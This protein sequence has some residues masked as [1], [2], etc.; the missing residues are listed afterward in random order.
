MLPRGGIINRNDKKGQVTIFVI[1]ALVIVVIAGIYIATKYGTTKQEVSPQ[2]SQIEEYYTSC[3]G[4]LTSQGISIIKNR[5]G[6]IQE[7]LFVRGTPIEPLSSQMNYLGETVPYWLYIKDKKVVNQAPTK[8]IMEEQLSNYIQSRINDCDFSQYS[9]RGFIIERKNSPVVEVAINNKEVITKVVDGITYSDSQTTQLVNTHQVMLESNLGLLYSKAIELY[10]KELQNSYIENYTIDI[11]RLYAPVD[12]VELSCA[13]IVWKEREIFNDLLRAIEVNMQ[14]IRLDDGKT[15]KDKE[16]KYFTLPIKSDGIRAYLKYSSNWFT[17]MSIEQSDGGI[18]IANPVGNQ[19]GLG[20]L[21]FC[22]VPYHLVYDLDYPL[23][24]QLMDEDGE[25][26]QY[27]IQIIIRKNHAREAISTTYDGIENNLCEDKTKQIEVRTYDE[28]TLTPIEAQ[29]SFK[30]LSEGC[31]LGETRIDSSNSAS[32]ILRT[33]QCVNGFLTAVAEGYEREDY[34]ISTNTQTSANILLKK[35]Y[36]IKFEVEYEDGEEVKNN[37]F[38]YFLPMEEGR[39]IKTLVWPEQKSIKITEG[40]YNITAY[41][42]EESNITLPATSEKK[43]FQV[44]RP[45]LGGVF[46]FTKEECYEV[47]IP[48]QR[49]NTVISGGG[50]INYYLS[51]SQ[52][53]D[54]EIR[55]ILPRT[56]I[57]RT[58]EA[59]QTAYAIVD[60]KKLII[61]Q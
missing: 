29:I 47:K 17:S 13:P 43:C 30:C 4:D 31:Y 2:F 18:I 42:Y 10:N 6:F 22:Y 52:I 50:K 19:Q 56:P 32:G 20:I 59:L 45:G 40:E 16:E 53:R 5:G 28:E 23:M 35:Q 39:E 58:I 46:G 51:Q 7:P 3:I 12:G 34:Q 1:I 8:K 24:I 61:T 21:G 25:Y 11:I 26:F 37:A 44:P 49:I 33:P 60:N 15:N 38:I 48:G 9:S 41:A 27:P 36:E 55:V 54:G 57:P 14:E